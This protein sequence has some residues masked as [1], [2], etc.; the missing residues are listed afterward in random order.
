MQ[1]NGN[2]KNSKIKLV[3]YDVKIYGKQGS[4]W[5]IVSDMAWNKT[6]QKIFKN[7][8]TEQSN[9]SI[10]KK[11]P[12]RFYRHSYK[13]SVENLLTSVL[14]V[15]PPFRV[16]HD[17]SVC[18]RL[19]SRAAIPISSM[20]SRTAWPISILFISSPGFCAGH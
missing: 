7:P 12:Q 5:G 10:T 15:G 19:C 6:E 20:M 4:K 2:L 9:F 17:W 3:Q 11:Y 16:I 8:K 13:W 14:P 18:M 1:W